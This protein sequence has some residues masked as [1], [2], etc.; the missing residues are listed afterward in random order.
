MPG[1]WTLP[2]PC[3]VYFCALE[4]ARCNS[5]YSFSGLRY[6]DP[7][8]LPSAQVVLLRVLGKAAQDWRWLT[9][10]F[11]LPNLC[12]WLKVSEGPMAQESLL[13]GKLCSKTWELRVGYYFCTQHA[14]GWYMLWKLIK[15]HLIN[16]KSEAKQ[17]NLNIQHQLQE[18]LSI[19]DP[20]E[21]IINRKESVTGLTKESCT[22]HLLQETSVNE[23]L[24]SPCTLDFPMDFCSEQPLQTSSFFSIKLAF[25]PFVC[26]AC[27]WFCHSL[28]V[29]N[30]NS[31][32]LLNNP[33]FCC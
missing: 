12:R 13:V 32:L 2:C 1:W 18:E 19:T 9:W 14:I 6:W 28:H 29:L 22:L 27:V 8:Q 15:G 31:L 7:I 16:V 17:G 4:R 23:K 24:S 3:T 30:R 11:Q 21:R 33:N 5:L 25:L 20:K 10:S 26:W